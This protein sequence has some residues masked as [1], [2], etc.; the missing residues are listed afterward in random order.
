MSSMNIYINNV[1]YFIYKNNL[2]KKNNLINK[3]NLYYKLPVDIIKKIYSTQN[4]DINKLKI[5][6]LFL[7]TLGIITYNRYIL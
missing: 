7:L 5:S 3:P 2:I 6:Y 1:K 4:I